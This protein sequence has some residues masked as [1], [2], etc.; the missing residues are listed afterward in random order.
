MSGAGGAPERKQGPRSRARSAASAA[1]ALLDA[2]NDALALLAGS[3]K[4]ESLSVRLEVVSSEPTRWWSVDCAVRLKNGRC[5]ARARSGWRRPASQAEMAGW[6][7]LAQKAIV[8]RLREQQREVERRER[9]KKGIVDEEE[10]TRR[11]IE[12]AA[13]G[14]LA[15]LG[16]TT[17]RDPFERRS[18]G[19][20]MP[21]LEE[22]P[23]EEIEELKE[24]LAQAIGWLDDSA[25]SARIEGARIIDAMRG[26]SG[27]RQS[28]SKKPNN[29]EKNGDRPPPRRENRRL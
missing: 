28:P 24:R 20:V 11:M 3:R 2:A 25:W 15:W 17:T 14:H 10:E 23:I 5:A 6:L 12:M 29:A 1:E 16:G 4:P 9:A 18:G 21:D 8:E 26:E 19:W 27:A 22:R 13:T 7:D